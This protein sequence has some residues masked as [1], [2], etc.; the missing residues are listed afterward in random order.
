[1]CII[2]EKHR[3]PKEKSIYQAAKGN[4]YKELYI[5]FYLFIYAVYI[6]IY[7]MQL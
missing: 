3:K 4:H 7:L 1:M 6:S 2:L 5:L